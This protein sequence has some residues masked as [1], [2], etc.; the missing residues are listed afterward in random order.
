M[1]AITYLP[2]MSHCG[3]RPIWSE[4][5]LCRSWVVAGHLTKMVRN[6]PLELLSSANSSHSGITNDRPIV[7]DKRSFNYNYYSSGT[8]AKNTMEEAGYSSERASP[9]ICESGPPSGQLNPV[10]PALHE[11]CPRMGS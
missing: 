4:K 5:T 2:G 3:Q 7:Y 8:L 1:R 9:G 11:W 6:Y 10:V